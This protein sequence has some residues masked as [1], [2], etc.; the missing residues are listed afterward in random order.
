MLG[1]VAL[2][3]AEYI[4]YSFPPAYSI[5][6]TNSLRTTIPLPTQYPNHYFHD[7]AATRAYYE[8]LYEYN[9]REMRDNSGT[10]AEQWSNDR[11]TIVL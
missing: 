5:T 1:R 4:C 11:R 7:I 6:L 10:I 9:D 8:Q 2:A 3:N